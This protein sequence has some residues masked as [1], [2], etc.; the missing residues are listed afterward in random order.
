M[1]TASAIRLFQ[2]LV[3]APISLIVFACHHQVSFMDGFIM[4]AG[5][6]LGAWIA[7][8]VAMKLNAHFARI[9]MLIILAGCAAY[10]LIF[11]IIAHQW[12]YLFR[13]AFI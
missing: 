9:M 4:G 11:R 8:K 6:F 7:A 5:G 3:M 1:V 10:I 13:M 2:S 12:R